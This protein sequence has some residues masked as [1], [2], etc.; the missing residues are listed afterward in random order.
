MRY[1]L[2]KSEPDS[3]SLEDLKADGKTAWTGVRNYQARNIMRD[4]MS[5]GDLVLFYHSSASPP[6]VV[7][8]ARVASDAYPD[9]TALDPS[10]PY[11]DEKSSAEEPR[12]FLVDVEYV[13]SFERAVPLA[14][15][16][17]DE[18]LDEMVLTQRSRLSVQPVRER[19]FEVVRELARATE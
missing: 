17:S 8:M 18:R 2:M 4:E 1:W 14:E 10:S 9:P 13:E 5:K 15:L 11:F 3:Y 19:E 7:G 12:W 6:A 16:K